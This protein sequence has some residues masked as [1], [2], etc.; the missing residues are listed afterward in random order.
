MG[1]DTVR[2]PIPVKILVYIIAFYISFYSLFSVKFLLMAWSGDFSFLSL[3]LND[4]SKLVSN[5]SLILV[6]YTIIGA[7]LGGAILG[8]TSL[9]KYSAKTKSL[10]FDHLC[11][12][13]LA[14]LLSIIIGIL[15]FCFLQSGLLILT[16]SINDNSSSVMVMLGYTGVGAIGAY[17]WDVFIIKLK[18]LSKKMDESK[19]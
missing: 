4:Y 13:L 15:I 2:L 17:N 6:I 5:K 19:E 11:G 7:I 18:N 12:Y 1:Q 10:D 14:P 3:I 9:H 8:I 16:G